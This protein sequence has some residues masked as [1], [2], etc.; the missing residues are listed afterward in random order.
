MHN[1]CAW[2]VHVMVVVMVAQITVVA[3]VLH[4]VLAILEQ[5]VVIIIVLQIIAKWMEQ[6]LPLTVLVI[7]TVILSGMSVI[8]IVVRVMRVEG[9]RSRVLVM[10]VGMVVHGIVHLIVHLIV[11]PTI[12]LVS[13]IE[14]FMEKIKILTQDNIPVIFDVNSYTVSEGTVNNTFLNITFI[15]D[16]LADIDTF[17]VVVE[18]LRE[19]EKLSKSI[20]IITDNINVQAFNLYVV[21]NWDNKF[22]TVG[23]ERSVW[24]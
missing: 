5:M 7:V 12:Q 24:M 21:A 3:M 15:W 14:V 4:I 16:T 8:Y 17:N 23:W 2:I 19:A 9:M 1:L 20:T 6:C 22:I 18:K 10:P 11:V 13:V